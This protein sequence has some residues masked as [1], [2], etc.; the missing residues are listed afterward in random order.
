[1]EAIKL[2]NISKSYEQKMVVNQLDFTFEQGNYY[3]LTGESGC[4]KTTVLNLI[5]GYLTPDDGE[6]IKDLKVAYLFQDEM[7]FSNLTVS[8][9]MNMYRF[10]KMGIEGEDKEFFLEI[11]A[12]LGVAPLLKKKVSTL[13]GGERQRVEIGMILMSNPDVILLDEPTSRL[14]M[15]NKEKLINLISTVFKAKT[16][17]IVVTIHGRLKKHN[18][19]QNIHLFS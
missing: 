10:G 3:L 4:G 15:E 2:V 14:D 19:R 8:E 1:M 11:L 12:P 5:A 16:L 9:N 17:I 13:S 7:L 6:V 18:F